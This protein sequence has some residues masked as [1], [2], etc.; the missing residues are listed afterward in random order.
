[1]KWGTCTHEDSIKLSDEPVLNKI[2]YSEWWA[3]TL[4]VSIH[5]SKVHVLKKLQYSEAMYMY[6]KSFNRV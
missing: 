2:R 1:M 6:S 5:W 3:C 4:E